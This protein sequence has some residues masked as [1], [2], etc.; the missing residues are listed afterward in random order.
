VRQLIDQDEIVVAG[1]R[2]D[3]ADIGEIARAEH[4]SR[5][6]LLE[7]SEPAFKICI[8]RMVAGHEPRG[9]GAD[10][11]KPQRLDGGFLDR[12]MMRQVEIVVAGKRQQATAVAQH[13]DS[14]HPRRIGQRTAKRP[15][16]ELA[17]L[18]GR[19]FIE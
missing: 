2:R 11:I 12:R 7:T 9:A 18:P 13:P 8:E 1:K 19:E 14:G 15:A 6:R 5:F 3:D 4:A 16:I 17:E 10:A